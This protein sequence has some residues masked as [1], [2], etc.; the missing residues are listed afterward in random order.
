MKDL[1]LQHRLR[2]RI[3]RIALQP[4]ACQLA[5][6]TQLANKLG[7]QEPDCQLRLQYIGAPAWPLASNQPPTRADTGGLAACEVAL[8]I[9]HVALSVPPGAL[10]LRGTC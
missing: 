3:H 5:G 10:Y 4:A 9:Q 1:L 7:Q 2:L 8:C 6:L